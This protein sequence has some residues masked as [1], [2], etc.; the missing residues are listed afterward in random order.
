MYQRFE[1]PT[2]R[3]ERR[4]DALHNFLYLDDHAF[5]S[6]LYGFSLKGLEMLA[7]PPAAEPK[8]ASN[9]LPFRRG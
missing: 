2:S 8:P 5:V 6:A 1:T 7:N 3:Y 9:L 4:M